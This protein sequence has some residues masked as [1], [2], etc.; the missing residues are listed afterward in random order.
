MVLLSDVSTWD[1][2]CVCNYG[3]LRISR[4]MSSDRKKT[5]KKEIRENKAKSQV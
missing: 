3:S 1:F 4:S 5:K 2:P